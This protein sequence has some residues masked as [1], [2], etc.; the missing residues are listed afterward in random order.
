MTGLDRDEMELLRAARRQFTPSREVALRVATAVTGTMTPAKAGQLRPAAPQATGAWGRGTGSLLRQSLGAASTKLTLVSVLALAAVGAGVAWSR[1]SEPPSRQVASSPAR[2]A[3]SAPSLLAAP[4]PAA[5]APSSAEP[6]R[7]ATQ[8]AAAEPTGHRLRSGGEQ[9]RHRGSR[10]PVGPTLDQELAA[11]HAAESA[12]NEHNPSAALALLKS[13][14]PEGSGQLSEERAALD[15]L[16][17]CASGVVP[18]AMLAEFLTAFPRSVYAARVRGACSG[19][20]V[21]SASPSST[22]AGGPVR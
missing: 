15:L 13:G 8:P 6:A 1:R 11:V 14:E 5:L 7:A 17:R 21:P 22:P 2:R 19:A 4:Q 18:R 10:A 12:L 20:P 16:A 3:R 9:K